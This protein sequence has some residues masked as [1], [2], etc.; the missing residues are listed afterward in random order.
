MDNVCS[1]VLNLLIY[2]LFHHCVVYFLLFFPVFNA[3]DFV[4]FYYI[5]VYL[6]V[7]RYFIMLYFVKY[8]IILVFE[9]CYSNEV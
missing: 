3:F 4:L 6:Q 8:I 9:G 2:I 5:L 7:Q 1:K